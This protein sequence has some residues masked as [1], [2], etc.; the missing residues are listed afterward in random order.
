MHA[1]LTTAYVQ[2]LYTC[3]AED[4]VRGLC[5][6]VQNLLLDCLGNQIYIIKF[7]KTAYSGSNLLYN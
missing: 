6:S 7:Q 2:M 1:T 4:N 5:K 3:F